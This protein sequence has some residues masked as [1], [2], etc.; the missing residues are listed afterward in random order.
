MNGIAPVSAAFHVALMG[1][2]FLWLKKKHPVAGVVV[3]VWGTLGLVGDVVL[4]PVLDAYTQA[5]A[6]NGATVVIDHG[7]PLNGLLHYR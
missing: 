5:H 2:G 4:K 6:V 3:G 7:S 1:V